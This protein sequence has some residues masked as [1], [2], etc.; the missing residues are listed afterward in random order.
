KKPRFI[1]EEKCKGCGKCAEVCPVNV[2]DELDEKIGGHRKLIY[3]PFPQAVPNTYVV[4]DAC[5]YG[6]KREEGACIGGCI[7][8]CIQC[9]ECPIAQCVKACKEEGADAVVLWQKQEP[10]DIEVDSI[11]IASGIEAFE[12][13]VGL[14]GYGVYQNV[15]T[16]MQ[17]ERLMNAGGPTGG[18]IIR[19]SDGAHPKR[20]AWIQCVGREKRVG[21]PYCSKVCCMIATKQSIIAKEH[22]EA[23]DIYIFNNHLKT[24]GKGFHEFSSK[25]KGY[26]VNYVKG[27][28]SE[29][30]ENPKTGNLTVKYEDLEKGEVVE[31][32]VDLLVLSTGLIPSTRN[33]R[34]AKALKVELDS[35]GFFKEK[36][37]LSAPLETNVEGI[38][39]CGGATGPTDISESVAQ[40]T[41]ASLKASK[42]RW[43]NGE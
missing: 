6:K 36:D 19:P 42:P 30:F 28:P 22:H 13:P 27:R 35:N 29:V 18:E 1:D 34:L 2:P 32:E 40:A 39:V 9:R 7:I 24:Y 14:Y 15:I 3:I 41:A 5:R 25:A 38:Y 26:G 4:D 10:V 16:N 31:L 8:D 20:I 43:T 12:P 37:G 21:I 17:F 33:K 23:V 11:I